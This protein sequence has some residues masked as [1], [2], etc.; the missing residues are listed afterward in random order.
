MFA[1]I[2]ITPSHRI[3]EIEDLRQRR[4][5]YQKAIVKG[6]KVG[7]PHCNFF[8]KMKVEIKR[9]LFCKKEK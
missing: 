5:S 3:T 4:I 8:V 6:F 7:T 2:V 9:F 1:A